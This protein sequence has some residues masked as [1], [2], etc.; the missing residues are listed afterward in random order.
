M[1]EFYSQSG[2]DEVAA[3]I[4]GDFVGRLL[5]VGAWNAKVFSNSRYFIERGWEAVL[6]E[7]SPAPSRGLLAEYGNHPKV[8]LV[9]AAAALRDHG[10]MRSFQISDDGYTSAVPEAIEQWKPLANYQGTL[11]VPQVTFPCLMNQFGGGFDYVS[12]DTEGESVA[13]AINI[14]RDCGLRP[15]VLCVEH[16]NR[17]VELMQALQVFGYSM[18]HANGINAV[19]DLSGAY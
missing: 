14:I 16:D 18:A 2:E 12:I 9:Q 8:H 7:F 17:L 1:S 15:R 3:K 10:T 11:W 6:M 4:F 13:L 19:L 5:D